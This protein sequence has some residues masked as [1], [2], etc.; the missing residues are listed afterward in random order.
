MR[1]TI[2][3]LWMHL[4]RL[5][6]HDKP[7]WTRRHKAYL[8]LFK[9]YSVDLSLWF[10][11]YPWNPSVWLTWLCNQSEISWTIWLLYSDQLCLHLLHIE[12]FWLLLWSYCPVLT[13]KDKVLKLVYVT[14]WSVQLSNRTKCRCTDSVDAT[15]CLNCFARVIYVPQICMYGNCAKTLDT[16]F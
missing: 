1:G 5:C 14:C 9:C 8:I 12:C 10:E 3:H 4:L 15:N 6:E 7:I 11:A 13:H 2:W 16:S